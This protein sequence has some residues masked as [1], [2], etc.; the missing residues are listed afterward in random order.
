MNTEAKPI[1]IIDDDA[2]QRRMIRIKLQTRGYEVNEAKDGIE[3]LEF[4]KDQSYSLVLLDIVMPQLNGWEVLDQ[5][6]ANRCEHTLPVVMMTA[7][8]NNY[9]PDAA[10]KR[11]ANDYLTK[12]IDF[13][14]LNDRL[15]EY[16]NGPNLEEE[17][18]HVRC[19]DNDHQHAAEAPEAEHSGH[20]SLDSPSC[21]HDHTN[22]DLDTGKHLCAKPIHS[23]LDG[24][25]GN[26]SGVF[27]RTIHDTDHNVQLS[28]ESK[29][30]NN[31]LGQRWPG[32]QSI[33]EAL[34]PHD[35]REVNRQFR[36]HAVDT[37]PVMVRFPCKTESGHIGWVECRATPHRLPSG[38]TVWDAMLL[39]VTETKEL[40]LQAIRA[41][42]TAERMSSPLHLPLLELYRRHHAAL[43]AGEPVE[44]LSADIVELE[45]ELTTTIEAPAATAD[46]AETAENLPNS[47]YRDDG[48]YIHQCAQCRR[49]RNFS[50]EGR[51]ELV[52]DWTHQMPLK[53]SH[54]ICKECA[55]ADELLT[56][57]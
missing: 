45:A 57:Q 31:F 56:T 42:E 14:K 9:D 3:A 22:S 36:A 25:I 40:E 33:F 17:Q 15:D 13:S 29:G 6:R 19:D 34:E 53:T 11:G 16:V 12:P 41:R 18:E 30:L 48:G 37:K 28:F 39:D 20:D 23:L 43:D 26:L 5:I 10:K 27:F 54:T 50:A 4:L 52:T 47:E 51:W 55:D 2:F 38:E 32:V 1:L 46:D 35:R 7:K 44:K 24:L 8:D 49:V 21:S